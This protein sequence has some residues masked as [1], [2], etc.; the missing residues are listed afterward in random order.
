M[1]E[2]AEH[3]QFKTVLTTELGFALVQK[4]LEQSRIAQIKNLYEVCDKC[5]KCGNIFH[6]RVV[7]P[8][9]VGVLGPDQ[10]RPC[11]RCRR[12]LEYSAAVTRL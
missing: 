10:A 9:T 3:S 4:H 12:L 1:H 11:P 8:T 2:V 6:F 7:V 5:T